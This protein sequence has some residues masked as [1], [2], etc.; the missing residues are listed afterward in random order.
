MQSSNNIGLPLKAFTYT[1]LEKATGGF[2]KVIGTGASG[3]V[4][5]G[6]LQDL[7]T[8]I[9][10]KKIDKLGHETDKGSSPV[11]SKLLDGR[12]TRTWSGC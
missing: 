6:Q 5:K 2:Q 12:T 3:I 1:E 11:K 7:S 8:H 10:V 9:A 4:Y